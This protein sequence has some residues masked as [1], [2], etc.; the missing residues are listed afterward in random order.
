MKRSVVR[1]GGRGKGRRN[2]QGR[3]RGAGAEAAAGVEGDLLALD[4]RVAMIQ[5]LIPWD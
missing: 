2:S 3:S 1:I 5:A 4:S